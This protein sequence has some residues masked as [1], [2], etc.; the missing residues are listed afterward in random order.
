MDYYR[1]TVIDNADWGAVDLG[2]AS[3]AYAAVGSARPTALSMGG[4]NLVFEVKAP[5]RYRFELDA[6]KDS[7]AR[8]R[9]TRVR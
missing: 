6:S 4:G 2:G 1:H 9:V 7:E 3:A 5:G 8:V